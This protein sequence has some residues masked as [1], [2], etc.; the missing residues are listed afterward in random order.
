[1]VHL[2]KGVDNKRNS[3]Y[4]ELDYNKLAHRC[5]ERARL[6]TAWEMS[7]IFSGRGKQGWH[8][9]AVS[10]MGRTSLP[11]EAFPTGYGQEAARQKLTNFK[12]RCFFA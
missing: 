9:I 8:N 4:N 1:M 3:Y 5:A 6:S 11:K 7:F 2:K 10:Q 12:P